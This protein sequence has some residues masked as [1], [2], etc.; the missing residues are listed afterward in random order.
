M[1]KIILFFF[2]QIFLLGVFWNDY[3]P[4]VAIESERNLCGEFTRG[5]A[6]NPNWLPEW[7]VIQEENIGDQSIQDYC[8]E[9]DY[10]YAGVPIWD[11]FIS[12]ER[13]WAEYLARKSIISSRST[14]PSL[15]SLDANI[16]R[17][18]IMKIIINTSD[19]KEEL[20]ECRYIFADVEGDWWCKYIEAA[21]LQWYI[22]WNEW[23]RPDDYVSISEALKLIFNARW[24]S[25]RYE[26]GSW[27]EDYISSAY[28]LWYTENKE[29]NYTQV[30]TRW[31]IFSTLAKSYDDFQ[32]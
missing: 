29:N 6:L 31:W 28:Y 17:K 25:K 15:Y 5:T 4:W 8:I 10:S 20:E 14:N 9:S 30:A 26:T 1:Q 32:N 27:Q 19:I 23:F 7:W 22:A 12:D 24:I 21:L 11:A 16:T 2:S 13:A 3:V 18:E